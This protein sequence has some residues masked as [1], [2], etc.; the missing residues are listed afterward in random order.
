MRKVL[1]MLFLCSFVSATFVACEE[2]EPE[3]EEQKGENK[4]EEDEDEDAGGTWIDCFYCDD[5][6]DGECSFCQGDGIQ[7]GSKVCDVSK[8]NIKN[9]FSFLGYPIIFCI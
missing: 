4:G 3:K 8:S 5:M 6:P 2:I 9:S 1:F 7:G